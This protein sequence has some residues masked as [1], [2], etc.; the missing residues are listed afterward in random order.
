MVSEKLWKNSTCKECAL[1][2]RP[3]NRVVVSSPCKNQGLLIVGEAPGG[4]ENEQ[5]MGFTGEAGAKLR[6]LLRQN[7]LSEGDYGLANICRCWP[8]DENNRDRKPL[9]GEINT[10]LK[11]LAS[12]I[13][14]TRPKVILAV[15]KTA[16]GI[17]CDRRSSLSKLIA[18]ETNN[19]P[20]PDLAAEGVQSALREVAPYIVP[21]PHTSPRLAGKEWEPLRLKQVKKAVQLLRRI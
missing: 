18:D 1:G 11:Y 14:D 5:G 9:A 12:L 3:G 16:A 2:G 10:C 6:T 15:G 19:K 13:T 4:L 8:R 17:L 20:S 7:G 21:M